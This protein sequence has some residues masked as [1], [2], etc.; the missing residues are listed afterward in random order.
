MSWR[1]LRLALLRRVGSLF[2]KFPFALSEVVLQWYLLG[3]A[4]RRTPLCVLL[5]PLFFCL[6]EAVAPFAAVQWYCCG[7]PRFG[8]KP[9][10]L[11]ELGSTVA[12]MRPPPTYAALSSAFLSSAIWVSTLTVLWR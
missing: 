12:F 8:S 6:V 3:P 1:S 2:A 5:W 7:Y 10:K 9:T 4:V 11:D